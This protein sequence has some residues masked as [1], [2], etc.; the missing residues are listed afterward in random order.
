MV[1]VLGPDPHP[2]SEQ[3]EAISTA[4]DPLVD[5]GDEGRTCERALVEA[6]I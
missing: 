5:E 6:R 2:R 1:V 4:D 3:S